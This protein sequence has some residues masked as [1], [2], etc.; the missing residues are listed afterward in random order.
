MLFTNH[1][2]VKIR[3]QNP[4]YFLLNTLNT[5]KCSVTKRT[6]ILRNYFSYTCENWQSYYICFVGCWVLCLLLTFVYTSLIPKL[7]IL[8]TWTLLIRV[9]GRYFISGR[10]VPCITPTLSSVSSLKHHQNPVLNRLSVT[11][12]SV[13]ISC[14]L[15]LETCAVFKKCLNFLEIS[16]FLFFKFYVIYTM[17]FLKI[18]TSTNSCTE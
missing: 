4:A 1:F 2:T 17:Y 12:L 5:A 9:V 11:A 8:L 3:K 10:S 16:T 15:I 14:V 6:R 7:N 13:A 18:T